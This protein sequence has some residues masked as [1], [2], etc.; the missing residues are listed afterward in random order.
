[1]KYIF[2]FNHKIMKK[3]SYLFIILTLAT[4]LIICIICSSKEEFEII[5][6]DSNATTNNAV[7]TTNINTSVTNT[8]TSIEDPTKQQDNQKGTNQIVALESKNIVEKGNPPL[9]EPK[10]RKRI[11]MPNTSTPVYFNDVWSEAY[12]IPSAYLD[13]LE[14]TSG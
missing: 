12:N 13:L 4:I 10:K 6:T 9:L 5:N 3:K 1:M 8:Q 11:T 7:S 2:S 14:D